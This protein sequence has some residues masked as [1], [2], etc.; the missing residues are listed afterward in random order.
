MLP[1]KL[2]RSEYFQILWDQY[3]P[4]TKAKQRYYQKLQTNIPEKYQWKNPLRDSSERDFPGGTVGKNPLANAGDT[5]LIPGPGRF[6][7]PRSN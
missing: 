5:G 7:M 6:C 1:K 3:Y 4:D 2:K